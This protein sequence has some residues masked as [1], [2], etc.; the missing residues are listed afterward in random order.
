MKVPTKKRLIDRLFNWCYCW[1][2][3]GHKY[4]EVQLDL[5]NDNTMPILFRF[6]WTRK[7]D[8]AGFCLSI[9]IWS[10]FFNV[11]FYDNRHWD[12]DNNRWKRYE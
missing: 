11:V 3:W 12:D 7:T 8:H 1:H 10:F 6:Q 4:F 9:G 5:V 2:L